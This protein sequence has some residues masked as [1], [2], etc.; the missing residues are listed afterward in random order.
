MKGSE[1]GDGSVCFTPRC[2]ERAVAWFAVTGGTRFLCAACQFCAVQLALSVKD[3]IRAHRVSF[4]RFVVEQVVAET[5]GV[6]YLAFTGGSHQ[7]AL[8][9]AAGK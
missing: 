3:G 5:R 4:R 2:G 7:D 1:D 8:D 6:S 9:A